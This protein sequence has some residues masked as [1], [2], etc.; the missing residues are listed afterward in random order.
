MACPAAFGCPGGRLTRC[1]G[2]PQAQLVVLACIP[3]SHRSMHELPVCTAPTV[4]RC[5]ANRPRHRKWPATR[6]ARASHLLFTYRPPPA[7]HAACCCYSAAFSLSTPS[8]PVLVSL[9]RAAAYPVDHPPTSMRSSWP[10]TGASRSGGN[11]RRHA[12]P[13][14]ACDPERPVLHADDDH[15]GHLR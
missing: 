9:D 5:P 6:F 3:F 14:S 7:Q 1:P 10:V 2:L 11:S 13:Q 8:P 4:L 15:D 12:A